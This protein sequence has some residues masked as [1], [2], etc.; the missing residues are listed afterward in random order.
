MDHQVQAD[1][2]TYSLSIAW[3][4]ISRVDNHKY[5]LNYSYNLHF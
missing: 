2:A 3:V 4:Y 5:I 1:I